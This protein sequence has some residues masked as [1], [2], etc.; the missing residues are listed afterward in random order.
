MKPLLLG[1]G[2]GGDTAAHAVMSSAATA[3]NAAPRARVITCAM[4]VLAQRPAAS[5]RLRALA[6]WMAGEGDGGARAVL[7]NDF[8]SFLV[9][10]TPRQRAAQPSLL[11]VRRDRRRRRRLA[12]QGR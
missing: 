5:D 12:A 3:A 1:S 6:G 8:F 9:V 7:F 11:R 2:P 4:A 10:A